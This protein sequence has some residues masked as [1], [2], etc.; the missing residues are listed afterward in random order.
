VATDPSPA[1]TDRVALTVAGVRLEFVASAGQTLVPPRFQYPPFLVEMPARRRVTIRVTTDPPAAPRGARAL[2]DTGDGWRLLGEGDERVLEMPRRDAG[3]ALLW[4]VSWT[5]PLEEAVAWVGPQLAAD[6]VIRHFVQYPLD[7]ILLCEALRADGA[8]LLHAAGGRTPAGG[9]A[10]AGPSG[11]GKSTLSRLLRATPGY[12]FLSD[13]RL[14]AVASERETGIHGTP[15]SGDAGI[16]RPGPAAL[17]AICFLRQATRNAVTPLEPGQALQ[18]LLPVTTLPWYHREEIDRALGYCARLLERVACY[19]L[20]FNRDAANLCAA[21]AD[22]P[23]A[24]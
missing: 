2:F 22:L 18:R 3:D 13:D 10:F 19:E 14:F 12:D 17:D 15:W 5:A 7:Q 8:L 23:D 6:G 9:I 11:A 21:L 4:R 24:A 20:A 16:A 1:P